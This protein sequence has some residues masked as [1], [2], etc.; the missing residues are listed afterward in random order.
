MDVIV[1]S[2][3]NI[4]IITFACVISVLTQKWI[5]HILG[6]KKQKQIQDKTYKTVSCSGRKSILYFSYYERNLVTSRIN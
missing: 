3:N 1:S 2:E 5:C 4:H 6:E